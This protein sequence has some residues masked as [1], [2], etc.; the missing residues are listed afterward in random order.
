M[1]HG[2]PSK[3]LQLEIED[4]LKDYFYHGYSARFASKK[5]DIDPKTAQNYF[6]KFITTYKNIVKSDS[7]FEKRAKE[8][9]IKTEMFLEKRSDELLLLLDKY[10][11]KL[12]GI[13]LI[14]KNLKIYKFLSDSII[15][16]N[17]TLINNRVLMSD[18]Y[19]TL[20]QGELIPKQEV[21]SN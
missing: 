18:N 20:T 13:E 17:S 11:E 9:K 21:L 12:D 14:D 16:I 7:D 2:R 5:L 1:N 6:N 15:K 10:N 8:Y 3:K 4:K 19:L